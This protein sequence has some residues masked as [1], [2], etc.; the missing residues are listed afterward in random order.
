MS[1]GSKALGMCVRQHRGR[2]SKKSMAAKVGRGVRWLTAVE[3]GELAPM[4]DDLIKLARAIEPDRRKAFLDDITILLYQEAELERLKRELRDKLDAGM[5]ED[6]TTMTQIYAGQ[7]R[8]L[9]PVVMAPTVLGHLQAYLEMVALDLPEY[10]DRLKAGAAEAALLTAVLMYRLGFTTEAHANS[11]IASGLAMESGHSV[12]HAYV[13]AVR[14]SFMYCSGTL[15]GDGGDPAQARVLLDQA[16]E[17]AGPSPEPTAAATFHAWRAV[18]HASLGDGLAAG[19]DLDMAD[20]ALS[21]RTDGDR[22]LIGLGVTTEL[23]LKIER[24]ICAVHL[25]QP[26]DVINTLDPSTLDGHP[27]TGWRAARMADLAAA[28]AQAGDQDEAV[29][30]LLRAVDLVEAARDPWRML[31]VQ[32]TRQRWLPNNHSG[33]GIEE[34]DRR[35]AAVVPLAS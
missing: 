8:L 28:H 33:A 29:R 30:L 7:S 19:R 22:D 21:K 23:D 15:G 16:I 25:G 11:L 4:W 26:R 14:E 2:E 20:Q 32:G 12:V 9:M 17:L 34:L 31:R 10:G 13:L 6:M 24:A 3:A 18:Q 35:L 5:A 27:S 1:R